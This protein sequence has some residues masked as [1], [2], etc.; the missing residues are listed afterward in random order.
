MNYVVYI[1][2]SDILRKYYVGSTENF[3]RRISQHNTGRGNFTSKGMPWTLVKLIECDSRTEAVG[4]ERKI[5][6]RGIERFLE[7]LAR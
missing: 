7:D 6:K 3:E 1:L 4:L 5:K 2:F